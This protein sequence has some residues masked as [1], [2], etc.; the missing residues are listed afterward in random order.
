MWGITDENRIRNGLKEIFCMT[1]ISKSKSQFK[2]EL[3]EFV[4]SE[5][6]GGAC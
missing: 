3:R 6:G 4:N 5:Q 1:L 2:E